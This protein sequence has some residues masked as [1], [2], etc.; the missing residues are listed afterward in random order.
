MG[1]S[2]AGPTANRSLSTAQGGASSTPRQDIR[3]AIVGEYELADGR[4]ATPVFQLIAERYLD[5]RYSPD[6]AAKACG[7]DAAL[8][9]RIAAEIAEVAFDQL[10]DRRR[11]A[12]VGELVFADEMAGLMFRRLGVEAPPCAVESERFAVGPARESHQPARP[13]PG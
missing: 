11:D 13:G 4:V 10:K 1:F 6:A 8:I 5:E 9:R 7:L 2:R 12:P 3:P